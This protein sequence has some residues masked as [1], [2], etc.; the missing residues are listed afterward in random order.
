MVFSKYSNDEVDKY[1]ILFAAIVAASNIGAQVNASIDIIVRHAFKYVK[2]VY[3][4]QRI[5]IPSEKYWR[6]IYTNKC[7]NASTDT[8][9]EGD[10]TI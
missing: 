6:K 8:D 3:K 1:T 10:S 2:F 7:D 9:G 4:A 5:A